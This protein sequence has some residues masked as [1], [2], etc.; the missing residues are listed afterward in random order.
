MMVKGGLGGPHLQ[1]TKESSLRSASRGKRKEKRRGRHDIIWSAWTCR[2]RGE[3]KGNRGSYCAVFLWGRGEG[4]VC[5][6]F[7]CFC[8]VGGGGGEM[9]APLSCCSACE[10]GKGEWKLDPQPGREEGEKGGGKK[11]PATRPYGYHAPSQEG[12]KKIAKLRFFIR[13]GK[14]REEKRLFA[15]SS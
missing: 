4:R 15:L 3:R 7:T 13:R 8:V 9:N 2:E 5:L 6:L 14:K 10:R 12:K 1:S 11:G